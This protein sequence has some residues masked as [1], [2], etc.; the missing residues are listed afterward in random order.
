MWTQ[1]I[2]V[3]ALCFLTV[4]GNMISRSTVIG[5]AIAFLF[6]FLAGLFAKGNG[7]I[8]GIVSMTVALSVIVCMVLYKVNEGFQSNI[9]F[10]FEGFFSL[11]ETGTWQTNSNEIL[12]NM[13]VLPDNLRTWIIGDGYIE[14]PLDRS[15][16]SFDPYYVGENYHGY[17]KGTDIGYLRYIFYFGVIGLVAFSLFFIEACRMLCNRF[18]DYKWVFVFVLIV[19]F[20]EWFKVSTDLFVVF[21]P[22]FCFTCEGN[23]KILLRKNAVA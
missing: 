6:L 20:I 22:F 10:G 11:A 19:N 9:R 17:Y 18:R 23:S 2:Y 13:V 12:K 14:N 1:L 8:L 5:S 15:L 7:K 4:V 21:A 16:Q 3:I